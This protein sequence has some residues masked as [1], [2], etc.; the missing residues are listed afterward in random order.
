MLQLSFS[1][2]DGTTVFTDQSRFGLTM[3]SNN[4]AAILSNKL[5]LDG[6]NDFVTASMSDGQGIP[7]TAFT[8]EA[9][10]V[11]FDKRDAT[12]V[13]A[14]LNNG[15]SGGRSWRFYISNTN[16]LT[17]QAWD[18]TSWATVAQ[19]N[20]AYTLGTSYDL[21]VCWDGSTLR[22]Y[23]DGVSVASGTISAF[24]SSTTFFRIGTESN[25]SGNEINFMDGRM[26]AL[27]FTRGVARGT[28]DTYT[29]HA[30]PL[31]TTQ[32]TTADPLWSN[33][34]MY[35]SGEGVDGS[36]K[37]RDRSSV[38]RITTAVG[39][40]QNDVDVSVNGSPSIL[41]GS[42]GT[43][44]LVQYLSDLNINTTTPD[45]CMEAYVLCTDV[46]QNNQLFGRR[47]DSGQF[48]F[49]LNAGD[50]QFSTFSGTT[51][52]VR[53]TAASGMVNNTVYHMCIQRSGTTYYVYTDGVLKGSATSGAGTI[54]TNTTG[55]LIG[56][57]ETN[58][59]TRYWRGSVN[60]AR[61]TMGSTRY[62]LS[63]FTPPIV[64]YA[65]I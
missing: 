16:F 20:W 54:S 1:G 22:I 41:L 32:A 23:V 21:A 62:T 63:G 3:V 42:D 26:T 55:L 34:V 52:T 48:I 37:F 6:T 45:F 18:G 13:I 35:V 44:V 29:R 5:E 15:A 56:D 65:T 30:L 14:C 59:A 40:A 50:L 8:L 51:G 25:G 28:G 53:I 38:D 46:S 60:H 64:P 33:V 47:R 27:R 19:Y 24:A 11:A 49:S 12:Q 31:T 61:I 39:S 9:F 36:T 17:F 58:Q 57:S 43:Y 2:T 10:G 4:G 7:G